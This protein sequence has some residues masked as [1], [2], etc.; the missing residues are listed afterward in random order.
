MAKRDPSLA[1]GPRQEVYAFERS[2]GIPPAEA[3]RRA[4]GKVENGQATKWERS[5]RVVNRIAYL[6]KLGHTDEM[7]EAKR[8]RIEERLQLAAF[9]NIFDFATINEATSKPVID[10]SAV[11]DSPYGVIIASFKFDKDSGLLTDFDRDNALQALAQLRDMHGFKAVTKTALTDPT[12]QFD[13]LAQ[14]LKEI[15]G[16]TR[17]LPAGA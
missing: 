4:G 13:S 2:L 1:L 15:D 12:G 7:L 8:A 6:R 10:W 9:G 17:G 3:C 14:V 5:R 11:A 16:R